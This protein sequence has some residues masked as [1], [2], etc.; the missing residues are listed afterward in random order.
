MWKIVFVYPPRQGYFAPVP[1]SGGHGALLASARQFLKD[2]T[3]MKS[4]FLSVNLPADFLDT[5][6][7]TITNFD[8]A[9]DDQTGGL[10]GQASATIGLAGTHAAARQALRA[11]NTIVNNTYKN[12]PAVRAEFRVS[13]N[14]FRD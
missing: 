4:Q 5:L 7:Q 2:A 6:D 9:T 3:P 10:E 1:C 13:V 12:N 14:D 11:L 8:S